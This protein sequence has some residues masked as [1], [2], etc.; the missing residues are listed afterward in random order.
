MG[1]TGYSILPT[2]TTTN[3]HGTASSLLTLGTEPPGTYTIHAISSGLSGSPCIFTAHSLRRFGNIAGFCMLK[4]GTVSLGTCSDIEVRIIELSTFTMTND[5]SYF[6]FENIPVGS[7]TISF[8]TW[9]AAPGKVSDVLI[10]NRQFE[11][12]TYIGT[13]SLLA[14]DTNNDGKVNIA[15][16][17]LFADAWREKATVTH[18]NWDE[19]KEADFDHDNRVDAYDFII[20]RNNFG[21]QQ[22]KGKAKKLTAMPTKAKNTSGRIE[23]SFDLETLEGV[24]IDELRVGNIIY[25]KI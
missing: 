11:D 4:L 21:Q 7:Y 2:K 23:L 22:Q 14:G 16:W 20:F 10:S 3:V 8:D 19:Y 12:T 17:P 9:G 24:D 6:I 13:I 18:T 25:L 1:A 15:D 5:N